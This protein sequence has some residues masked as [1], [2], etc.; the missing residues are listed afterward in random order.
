M[1][2]GLIFAYNMAVKSALLPRWLC[3]LYIGCVMLTYK[4]GEETC[5]RQDDGNAV[6]S[7]G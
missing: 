1:M 2:H 3:D 6:L 4:K 7:C 5:H